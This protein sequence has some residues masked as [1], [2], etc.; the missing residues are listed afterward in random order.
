MTL[1]ILK[2][3]FTYLVLNVKLPLLSFLDVLVHLLNLL[4]LDG[5]LSAHALILILKDLVLLVC[6]LDRLSQGVNLV[7]VELLLVLKLLQL[8]LILLNLPHSLLKDSLKLLS[9]LPQLVVIDFLEFEFVLI[10]PIFHVIELLLGLKDLLSLLLGVFL[11][12]A[13]LLVL[14]D[15]VSHLSE[16]VVDLNELRVVLLVLHLSLEHLNVLLKL[17]NLVLQ[18]RN[19]LSFLRVKN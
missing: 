3:D 17:L 4:A 6:I 15:V 8:S 2:T 18:R 1:L 16:E 13:D 12:G 7:L 14:L 11:V 19:L 9:S 10:D 5:G